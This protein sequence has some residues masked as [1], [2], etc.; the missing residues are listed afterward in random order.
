M[1]RIIEIQHIENK[2][3]YALV[4]VLL[5]DGTEAT[6]YVGGEVQVYLKKNRINAFVKKTGDK[7]LDI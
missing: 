2:D 5:D 6:T 1:S 4:H 7:S 3:T